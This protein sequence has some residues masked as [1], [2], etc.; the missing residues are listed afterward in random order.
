MDYLVV[1]PHS[2]QWRLYD[3]VV[4]AGAFRLLQSYKRY[5]IYERVR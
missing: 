4:R 1:G 2:K 3:P 5:Q